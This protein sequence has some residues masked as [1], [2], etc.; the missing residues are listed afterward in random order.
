MKF[1]S[2]D[3]F[4]ITSSNMIKL[5]FG[6]LIVPVISR[7]VNPSDLGKL[8]LLMAFGPFLNQFISLGLT[9]SSVKFY[10][11]YGLFSV[12]SFM[13]NKI[14]KRALLVSVL[15][16][17]GFIFYGADKFGL[18]VII[19]ILYATS[20]FF[21]NISFLSINQFL[22]ENKFQRYA[23]IT[24]F[25][26]IVRQS[27]TLLL[28]I[29]MS[30]KLLGLTLG[31]LISNVFS[32]VISYM[33]YPK[34][35]LNN[36]EKGSL[37]ID[38]IKK[39]KKYSLPLFFL[40][41]VGLLYQSSDRLLVA[42]FGHGGMAQLGYLGMAQ[43]IIAIMTIALSGLFTVWG[44]KAFENYSDE[45][46][47]KEKEKLILLMLGVLIAIMTG[48]YL[49]K[50][51]IIKFLLTD[52]YKEAFPI[53]IL[54]IATFVNNRIR[55]ILEKFFLKKGHTKLISNVFTIFGVISI[56]CSGFILYY[57]SLENMLVF[58]LLIALIHA[59]T[60]TILLKTYHQKINPLLLIANS[61]L[62]LIVTLIMKMKWL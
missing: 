61:S 11:E 18:T 7:Y 23:L 58:R 42:E 48:L 2:K 45:I 13:Q 6:L 47:I 5:V 43:R 59:I 33:Y 60:L 53:S 25:S 56:V 26:T 40:G 19:V 32:V 28:V 10:K 39:I 57:S 20:V 27:V 50:P 51:L 35:I 29:L 36:Y 17:I 31:L 62:T 1:L 38:I 54:L 14:I 41:V 8:D 49:F 34:L 46:L 55:E 22:N 12:I 52:S 15:F 37:N 30:D 3:A 9:N 4:W 24:T 16:C 21:E 44:V